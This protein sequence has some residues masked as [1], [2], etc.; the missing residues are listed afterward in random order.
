MNVRV[1]LMHFSVF[2]F[3]CIFWH[4]SRIRHAALEP[5]QHFYLHFCDSLSLNRLFHV[6][7][8]TFVWLELRLHGIASATKKRLYKMMKTFAASHEWMKFRFGWIEWTG[9]SQHKVIWLI[10]H[11]LFHQLTQ[12]NSLIK[13]NHFGDEIVDAM[14]SKRFDGLI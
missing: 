13:R 4:I 5:Y 7:V 8:S 11:L 12:F 2:L 6:L 10:K 14:R 9:W 1:E 3:D